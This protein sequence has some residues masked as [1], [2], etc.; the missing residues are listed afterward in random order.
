MRVL[1]LGAFHNPYCTEGRVAAAFEELGHDVVRLDE[2][3]TCAAQILD[4]ARSCEFDLLLFAKGR[5]KEAQ[6]D[7]PQAAYEIVKLLRELKA[8]IPLAVCWHWDLVADDYAPARWQWQSIVSEAVDLTVLTDGFSA[9]RLPNAIVIR[10]GA[11]LDDVNA[12]GDEDRSLREPMEV[13]G[14]RRTTDS[15]AAQ[16]VDA[17]P[18]AEQADYEV[19]HA[20]FVGSAYRERREWIEVTRRRLGRRFTHIGPGGEGCRDSHISPGVEM[21]GAALTR[22]MR[23]FRLCLQPPWPHFPRYWS[24]RITVLGARGALMVAPVVQGMDEDGWQPGVNYLP[25]PLDFQQYAAQVEEY[26]ERHDRRQLEKV[27]QNCIAHARSL[28]WEKRVTEFLAVLNAGR[29]QA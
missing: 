23:S 9:S 13:P 24:D 21:R 7:W 28:T 3:R 19:G 20:L 1:Y 25:A 11:Q 18:L 10:D 14:F 5:F 2:A 17:V 26:L 27:R 15:T 16:Q 6:G 8:F 29:R 22:L 4:A 12:V